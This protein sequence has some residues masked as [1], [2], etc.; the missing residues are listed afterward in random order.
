MLVYN[1]IIRARVVAAG[2]SD[3]SQLGAGAQVPEPGAQ[4]NSALEQHA[5]PSKATLAQCALLAPAQKLTTLWGSS[6]LASQMAAFNRLR[7]THHSHEAHAYGYDAD[8]NSRAAALSNLQPNISVSAKHYHVTLTDK[9]RAWPQ[10]LGGDLIAGRTGGQKSLDIGDHPHSHSITC[11]ARRRTQM[12]SQHNI[13]Q[14]HQVCRH[15]WFLFINIEARGK[16][17]TATQAFD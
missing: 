9:Q 10:G 1:R 3:I 12:G 15:F 5:K 14:R 11:V 7:C 13:P 2:R 8:G 6:R 17:S 4:Y 16:N